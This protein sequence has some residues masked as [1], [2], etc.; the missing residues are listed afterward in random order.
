MN[1][2][3]W[4]WAW[5]REDVSIALLI[6]A[7]AYGGGGVGV[8][9]G[10]GGGGSGVMGGGGYS[11]GGYHGGGHYGGGYGGGYYGGS[12]VRWGVSVPLNDSGSV[13]LGVG[14]GNAYPNYNN[15]NGHYSRGY[16]G[17]DRHYDGGDYYYRGNAEYY[18]PRGVPVR[19]NAVAARTAAG[20]HRRP[21]RTDYRRAT[22]RPAPRRARNSRGSWTA[23]PPARVGS[24]T[25]SW[26]RSPPRRRSRKPPTTPRRRR[27]PKFSSVWIR[28]RPMPIT[29]RS[30]APG[31]SRS[32]KPGCANTRGPPPSDS[33]LA[34]AAAALDG[35]LD[36]VTTGAGW[37]KHLEVGELEKISGGAES[38]ESSSSQRLETILAK[39]DAVAENPQYRVIAELDGFDATRGALQR[40][41]NR[42]GDRRRPASRSAGVAVAVAAATPNRPGALMEA[43]HPAALFAFGVG[44]AFDVRFEFGR[45]R[46][47]AAGEAFVQRT[48]RL[49]PGKGVEIVEQFGTRR[50]GALA[51]EVDPG[52]GV[53]VFGLAHCRR[54]VDFLELRQARH[55][56]QPRV[57]PHAG[58]VRRFGGTQ[59]RRRLEVRRQPLVQPKPDARQ[60]GVQ[61]GVRAFVPQVGL[62]LRAV[63]GEDA[64][65]SAFADEKRPAKR[66]RRIDPLQIPA[67]ALSS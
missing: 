37:K 28:P 14:G 39:F 51:E 54:G 36:G 3:C 67:I 4:E 66:Q 21:T 40:Y 63:E 8:G 58:I 12:G 25:S 35:A 61:Q 19:R 5:G 17:G 53:A 46:R 49:P 33:V 55:D 50:G 59:R 6:A 11:S 56:A 13:R 32:C 62:E 9:I 60:R 34:A 1:R 15:W 2:R 31:A 24:S 23:S 43:A 16:Y 18:T 26:P 42:A 27:W 44:H 10:F 30:P 57:P 47:D 65:Q 52:P 45:Q 48:R 41:I 20:A 29:R 38:A 7:A 22:P 64:A